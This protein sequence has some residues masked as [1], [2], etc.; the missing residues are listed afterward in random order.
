M[1]YCRF[2]VNFRALSMTFQYQPLC[3]F[4]DAHSCWL[5]GIVTERGNSSLPSRCPLQFPRQ[6]YYYIFLS[7]AHQSIVVTLHAAHR[8]LLPTFLCDSIKLSMGRSREVQSCVETNQL[9]EKV[10]ILSRRTKRGSSQLWV[11][12]SNFSPREAVRERFALYHITYSLNKSFHISWPT[13]HSIFVVSF[14]RLKLAISLYH[15]AGVFDIA[16]CTGECHNEPSKYHVCSP[17]ASQ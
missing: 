1:H 11:R 9:F 13:E 6:R 2:C 7:A 14:P 4:T 3:L 10:A 12:A 17:R 15:L 16:D 5:V 8:G